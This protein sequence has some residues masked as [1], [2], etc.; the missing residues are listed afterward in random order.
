VDNVSG[1]FLSTELDSSVSHTWLWPAS[2]S[3]NLAATNYAGSLP[4]IIVCHLLSLSVGQVMYR[5][6]T[7]T[8]DIHGSNSS[9]P[10]ILTTDDWPNPS[11]S[12]RTVLW[13]LYARFLF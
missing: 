12:L 7:F 10:Q 11:W 6:I 13:A 1:A 5:H 2:Q 4:A 9:L 8:W 3:A